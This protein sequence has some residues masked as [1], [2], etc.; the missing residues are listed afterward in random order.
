[1][2]HESKTGSWFENT[3]LRS[4]GGSR[5]LSG[6]ALKGAEA[7]D[8]WVRGTVLQNPLVRRAALWIVILMGAIP[9]LLTFAFPSP[10]Q[11]AALLRD[12]RAVRVN[13]DFREAQTLLAGGDYAPAMD[14]LTSALLKEPSNDAAREQFH[15]A[16]RLVRSRASVTKSAKR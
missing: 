15:H 5:A 1:M 3:V 4:E 7:C 8:P 10:A 14:K 12:F 16:A 9:S 11:G 2:K 13:R 6:D